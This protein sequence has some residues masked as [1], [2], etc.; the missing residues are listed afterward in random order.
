MQKLEHWDAVLP[1]ANGILKDEDEGAV[2]TAWQLGRWGELATLLE[3]VDQ[4][5][6]F[7]ISIGRVLLAVH[8]GDTS[9]VEES[10]K[11]ARLNPMGP[12]RTPSMET[13][14][15]TIPLSSDCAFCWRPEQDFLALRSCQELEAGAP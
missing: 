1:I 2:D 8:D 6:S 13:H 9:R 5:S 11:Q 7:E 15:W 10:L 4:S 3:R 12:L 14:Q